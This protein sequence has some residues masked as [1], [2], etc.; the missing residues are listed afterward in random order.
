[1]SQGN[2]PLPS[3]VRKDFKVSKQ[4]RYYEHVNI[5][6]V[7]KEFNLGAQRAPRCNLYTLVDRNQQSYGFNSQGTKRSD[8]IKL[9]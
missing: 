3:A 9:K 7:T 6:A 2:L 4:L 5:V 1:M 8:V